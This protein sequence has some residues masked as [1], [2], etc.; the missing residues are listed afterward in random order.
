MFNTTFDVKNFSNEFELKSFSDKKHNNYCACTSCSFS[1]NKN[2][3]N[4]YSNSAL[5]TAT[6]QT[7]ANYLTKGYWSDNSLSEREWNLGNSGVNYKSGEISYSLGNNSLD[8]DGLYGGISSIYKE[9]F[10]LYEATLGINFFESTSYLPYADIDIIDYDDGA[11]ASSKEISNGKI[12]W[13]AINISKTWVSDYGT[14]MGSYLWLTVHHE[15]GHLLGLGHLGNYNNSA[16]YPSDAKFAN[17]SWQVSMM[18][19]FSQGQN[20]TINADDIN[21]LTPSAVDWI[22]LDNIYSDYSGFGVSNAFN[23]DT[24]FGFNTNISSST[25]EIWSSFSSKIQT[26]S[27]CIVDGSGN[28]TLD[29]SEMTS[30][31]KIDLRPTD[32][33]STK[34]YSSDIAGLKGNLHIAAG[35]FIENCISGSGNDELIGNNKNNNLQSGSGNDILI[36][37]QGKDKLTSGEGNDKL[38]GGKGEDTAV[39]SAK[40][41]VVNLSITKQQNTNEGL[42]TLIS[43][44]NISSGGG[45]DKLYGSKGSNTLNG[46]TG[47]DFL[48]GGYGS[49]KLIGGKGNDKLIGGKGKDTVVFSSKSNVIKLSITKKQNTKDGKDTLIGIENVSAGSGNDKVFGNKESNVLNGGTGDDLLVGGKGK[50]QLI[51]GKGKDTFE[52]SKGEGYDLIHDFENNKDKIFIGSMKKLKL[53]NKGNDVYIYKGKDLLAKVKGAKEDLSIKGKYIV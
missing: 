16:T 27:Y 52:L 18:S 42:D 40:S 17:D 24:T 33:N 7:M 14:D 23:G 28:D 25:S 30:N 36:G 5:T 46:G 2:N 43:V 34:L 26:N 49:D 48:S 9:S 38:I 20:T 53:K 22:A 12:G 8:N 41:N 29:L 11:Y 35:T 39:F 47:S 45:N 13:G 19:Y 31:D 44:E 6:F 37:G 50:D 32:K 10:K 21:L 1:E 51:G 4:S 15:I 3:T